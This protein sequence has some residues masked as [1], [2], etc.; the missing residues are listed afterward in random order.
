[1]PSAEK[2][3]SCFSPQGES[4]L[5]FFVHQQRLWIGQSLRPVG[6]G[7][8]RA[9]GGYA[10]ARGRTSVSDQLIRTFYRIRNQ[11]VVEYGTDPVRI[12]SKVFNDKEEIVVPKTYYIFS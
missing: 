7:D 12:R 9:G 3:K 8:A 1:M 5:R 11:P 10:T 6:G 4:H 2:N